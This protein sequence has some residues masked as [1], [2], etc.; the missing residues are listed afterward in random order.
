M[1]D[2]DKTQPGSNPAGDAAKDIIAKDVAT[3]NGGRPGKR[4][5][6]A[7]GGK[8]IRKPV[9]IGTA[10]GVLALAGAGVGI[11]SATNGGGGSHK[12]VV[13]PVVIPASS[14]TITAPPTQALNAL[15]VIKALSSN[16]VVPVTT[17]SVTAED[18][19]GGQLSYSWAMIATSPAGLCGTPLV[20]W[21]R[22]GSTVQWSHSH[23]PPDNCSHLTTDHPVKAEV[24]IKVLTGRDE[25][26][27]AICDLVG[28]ESRAITAPDS[29]C[30]FSL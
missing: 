9:V 17:Y 22:L 7:I 3:D 23:N 16:L 26:V 13:T 15:L 27:T 11:Y 24:T 6:V 4:T 14:T 25:G 10:A 2:G 30:R 5:G 1:G 20:P 18:V 21:T 19:N 28:S 12:A 29:A 8:T